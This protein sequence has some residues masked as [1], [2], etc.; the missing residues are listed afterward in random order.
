MT[1]TVLKQCGVCT[2]SNWTDRAQKG[3]DTS[4]GS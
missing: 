3:N 2:A 1:G 4:V